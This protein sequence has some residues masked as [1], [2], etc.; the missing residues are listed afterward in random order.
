MY[1]E[2]KY[3]LRLQCRLI[4]TFSRA[5]ARL[6]RVTTPLLHLLSQYTGLKNL[7][8]PAGSAPQ[9]SGGD[10]RCV[11]IHYGQSVRTKLNFAQYDSEAYRDLVLGTFA[12]FLSSTSG[13]LARRSMK[14]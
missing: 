4:L 11:G 10:Y 14:K 5:T 13:M 12:N 1:S 9:T 3:P 8:I 6:S 2:S 7:T